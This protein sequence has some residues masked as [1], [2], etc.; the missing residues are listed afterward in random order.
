[1]ALKTSPFDVADYL[2]DADEIFHY[3]DAELETN[4]PQYLA[5]ALNAVAR[6]RGGIDQVAEESGVP[7]GS[8]KNASALDHSAVRDL[9]I[10]VMEG[11]RQRTSS[12][13]QVA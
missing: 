11:Y 5:E 10:K 8:L 1:M 7:A 3:L 4:E 12:D 6:A 13:S 9:T 2:T